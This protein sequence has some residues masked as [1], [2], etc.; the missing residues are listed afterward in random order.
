MVAE[1]LPCPF[2]GGEA[3]TD[4]SDVSISDE[5]PDFRVSCPEC[6]S[7]GPQAS[8]QVESVALWNARVIAPPPGAG[9]ANCPFC[10]GEV[11][12]RIREDPTD[13]RDCTIECVSCTMWGPMGASSAAEAKRWW[14]RRMP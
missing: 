4:P 3:L 7:Y 5:P 11:Q 8:S 13:M 12:I 9:L 2:C 10:G 14:N 6:V 1:P